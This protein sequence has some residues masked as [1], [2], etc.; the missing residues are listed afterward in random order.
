MV[1]M[2]AIALHQV[3]TCAQETTMVPMV[4]IMVLVLKE[5]AQISVQLYQLGEWLL[6]FQ[7][8]DQWFQEVLVLTFLLPIVMDT[9]SLPTTRV[10]Y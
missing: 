10:A 2:V 6:I 3:E 1:A 4:Q 9:H 5:I 8:V 7:L